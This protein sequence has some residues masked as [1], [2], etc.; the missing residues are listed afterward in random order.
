MKKLKQGEAPGPE[1]APL[2]EIAGDR[3][4]VGPSPFAVRIQT[5]AMESPGAKTDFPEGSIITI[6]PRRHPSA[7][8]FVIVRLDR[9]G[10]EC[11][12]QWNVDGGRVFLTP[13]NPRYQAVELPQRAQVLGVAVQ[14]TVDLIPEGR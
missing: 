5:D 4:K 6:D 3:T 12:R 10:T 9:E 7:R 14:Y 1:I 11:F 2:G 13:L 8:D